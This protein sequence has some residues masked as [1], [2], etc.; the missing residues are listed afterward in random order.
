MA[1]YFNFMKTAR[2]A[3]AL[4]AVLATSLPAKKPKDDLPFDN[5]M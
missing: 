2:R 5:Q 3:I 1:P 4:F